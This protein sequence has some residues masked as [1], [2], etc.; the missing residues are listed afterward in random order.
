MIERR[1]RAACLAAACLAVVACS[2]FKPRQ[3]TAGH[4]DG[5]TALEGGVRT[6]SFEGAFSDIVATDERSRSVLLARNATENEPL[7]FVLIGLDD[8]RILE[9]GPTPPS[10]A[11]TLLPTGEDSKKKPPFTKTQ[12]RTPGW[13]L[14]GTYDVC[15]FMHA[16]GRSKKIDCMKAVM[17]ATSR[18][19]GGVCTL[20][21]KSNGPVVFTLV[22]EG[23][24]DVLGSGS[25]LA[26]SLDYV[27]TR[28]RRVALRF[29]VSQAA[30][31]DLGA[32]KIF[33]RIPALDETG[34]VHPAPLV[35]FGDHDLL[36]CQVD[37][38]ADRR[39]SC[40]R[41]EALP[42]ANA[43]KWRTAPEYI[44]FEFATKR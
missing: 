26:A 27:A 13:E 19:D 37:P 25:L 36:S 1:W 15:F 22:D 3:T 11:Q 20:F 39:R 43:S 18:C 2:R 38:H 17:G 21:A 23:T 31:I 12:K 6:E 5:E 30:V 16:S 35:W 29:G 8:G 10:A 7:E 32:K 40:K 24:G 44:R 28:N 14:D 9:R 4:V 42:L 41:I 33:E 34:M